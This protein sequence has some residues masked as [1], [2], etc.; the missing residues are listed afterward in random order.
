VGTA[1]TVGY[2]LATALL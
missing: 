1:S 2:L